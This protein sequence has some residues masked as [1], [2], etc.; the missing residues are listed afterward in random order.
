[1]RNYR[2][3]RFTRELTTDLSFVVI[4]AERSQLSSH[5]NSAMIL[6]AVFWTW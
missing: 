2:M 1:M 4:L 3:V 5:Q 6:Y